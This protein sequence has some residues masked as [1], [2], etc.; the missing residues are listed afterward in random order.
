MVSGLPGSGKSYFASRLALR[1]G[2]HYIT[3]DR[4]RKAMD[5]MGR[6]TFEDKLMV[7]EQMVV[8]ARDALQLG[9]DMVVD[10]TFYRQSF[11]ELFFKLADEFHQPI[12][13]MEVVADE[14]VV[15]ERLLRPRRESEADYNVYLHIK[16]QFENFEEPHLVLQSVNGTADHNLEIALEYIKPVHEGMRH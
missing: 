6:Y 15:K 7:Y 3:S 4:T 8:L 11:R 16:S 14:A 13:L 12:Y 9:N 1:L 2:A 10:A 5:R